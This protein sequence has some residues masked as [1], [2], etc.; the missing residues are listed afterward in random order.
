LVF[1]PWETNS[2]NKTNKQKQSQKQE[3]NRN[4]REGRKSDNACS[5][6][7]TLEILIFIQYLSN[8][9]GLQP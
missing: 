1:G 3:T 5:G 8:R 6:L 4:G 7:L 9:P 2:K